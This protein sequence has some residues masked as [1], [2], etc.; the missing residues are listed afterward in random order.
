MGGLSSLRVGSAIP[1]RARQSNSKAGVIPLAR[2]Y[3]M[4]IGLVVL[5]CPL[6]AAR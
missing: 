3:N 4:I 1:T 5:S 6:L 2:E